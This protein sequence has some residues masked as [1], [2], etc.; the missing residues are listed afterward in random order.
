MDRYSIDYYNRI[1]DKME[2]SEIYLGYQMYSWKFSQVN[3]TADCTEGLPLTMFDKVICGILNIDGSITINRLGEILGLNIES[4]VDNNK[5]SDSAEQELLS[6]A[7]DSLV[8]FNMVYHNYATGELSLTSIGKEY[9][10]KSK[11]SKITRGRKFSLYF[12]EISMQHAYAKDVFE[13][14]GGITYSANIFD[15]HRNE[16]LIKQF[17]GSQLPDVYDMEKGNSFTNLEPISANNMRLAVYFAV[18]YNVQNGTYRLVGFTKDGEDVK[19][20]AFFTNAVNIADDPYDLKTRIVNMF[21]NKQEDA[22]YEIDERQEE[23]DQLASEA[24][25]MYSFNLYNNEDPEPIAAKFQMER[26]LFEVECFFS[27]LSSFLDNKTNRVF[28]NLDEFTPLMSYYFRKLSKE[29]PDLYLFI[30]FK[31]S[32]MNLESHYGNMFFLKTEQ[33]GT[34]SFCCTDDCRYDF[35]EYVPQNGLDK[36]IKF[37]YKEDDDE[38]DMTQLEG[39]FAQEFVPLLYREIVAYLESNIQETKEDIDSIV[40]C[41]DKLMVF[42]EW[43]AS[44]ILDELGRIKREVFNS[45]KRKHEDSLIN[46]L[47]TIM[48]EVNLESISKLS[49]LQI[50]QNKIKT[51]LGDSDA[52]YVKLNEVAGEYKKQLAQRER[53]IK[54]E[55]MAKYYVIDTN[56]F[57]DDP[58]ILSYIADRDKVIMAA[59]VI[60]ELDTMKA[61]YKDQRSENARLAAASIRQFKKKHKKRAL[62]Q[63]ANVSVLPSEYSASNPD[64]MILAV[65]LDNNNAGLNICVLTSDNNFMNKCETCNIPYV[66]LEDFIKKSENRTQER[67]VKEPVQKSMQSDYLDV[68]MKLSRKGPVVIEKY[69]VALKRAGI[70]YTVLGFLDIKDYVRSLPGLWISTSAKG[71]TYV[72]ANK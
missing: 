11:K 10:S 28:F 54:D 45:T 2:L 31:E 15:E 70:D 40:H 22:Q 71:I 24:Q 27:N 9:Y 25:G 23:F 44:D 35:I 67:T 19:E 33:A 12:D 17:I 3:Y 65:A 8:T 34:G 37:V 32:E 18:I 16:S 59:R 62:F 47:N 43:I 66:S 60:E 69:D 57:V 20:N 29:R 6:N 7:I 58:N 41:D 68:Y 36:V 30:L 72:N 49:I 52:T 46:E 51:L 50:W 48:S 5:Y 21:L 64:N 42:R 39:V 61:K 53:F 55:L 14:A 1:V 26:Q 38:I 13:Y 56:V 4:D 63:L